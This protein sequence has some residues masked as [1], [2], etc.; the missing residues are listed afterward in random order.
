MMKMHTVRL[1]TGTAAMFVLVFAGAPAIAQT[2]VPGPRVTAQ[3]DTADTLSEGE[4]RSMDKATGRI[5]LR[6]GPLK[7]LDMP[8]MTMVFTVRDK[9]LLDKVQV[10]DKVRFRAIDDG[11]KYVVTEIQAAK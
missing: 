5:T 2:P 11:G 1:I 3:P 10:G 7:N 9:A 6:H 4:V 8:P